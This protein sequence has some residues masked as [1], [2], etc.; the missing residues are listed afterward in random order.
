MLEMMMQLRHWKLRSN[1]PEST[2]CPLHCTMQSLTVLPKLPVNDA[3]LLKCGNFLKALPFTAD[4]DN[5]LFKM[6][7]RCFSLEFS[8]TSLANSGS[9]DSKS[10]PLTTLS[11]SPRTRTISASCKKCTQRLVLLLYLHNFLKRIL[12]NW[13]MRFCSWVLLNAI[14]FADSYNQNNGLNFSINFCIM[15]TCEDGEIMQ[16][17]KCHNMKISP[18]ASAS[19]SLWHYYKNTRSNEEEHTVNEL[20]EHF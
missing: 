13:A 11:I 12:T 14:I 20:N 7:R 9:S 17:W 1:D 19:Y 15:K 8:N 18:S 5:T 4:N 16:S 6:V 3:M 2:P 10:S